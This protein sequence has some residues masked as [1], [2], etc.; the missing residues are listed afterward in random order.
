MLNLIQNSALKIM[1]NLSLIA[2]AKQG[3]GLL[4]QG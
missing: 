4:E 2:D 1:R 3:E